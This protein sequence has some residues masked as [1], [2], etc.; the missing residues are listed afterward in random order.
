VSPM[1]RPMHLVKPD[2]THT[3]LVVAPEA[4]EILEKIQVRVASGYHTASASAECSWL[5]DGR[6]CCGAT[7]P[8][9][10]G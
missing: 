8:A 2:M 9:A 7:G 6:A 1:D 3:R 5:S 4:L 10:C